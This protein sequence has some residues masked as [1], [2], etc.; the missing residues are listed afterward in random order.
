[1][2]QL[3][4]NLRLKKV[5]IKST[6]VPEQ[7]YADGDVNLYFKQPVRKRISNVWQ[8]AYYGYRTRPHENHPVLKINL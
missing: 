4:L 2:H 3:S 6:F 1:M 5:K 8:R 7:H